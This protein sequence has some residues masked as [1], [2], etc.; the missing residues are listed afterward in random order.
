M[1]SP[2]EAWSLNLSWVAVLTREGVGG[3]KG[4]RGENLSSFDGMLAWCDVSPE[5]IQFREC[6]AR[7]VLTSPAVEE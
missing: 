3:A 6:F 7:N 5:H 1:E 2:L 4:K